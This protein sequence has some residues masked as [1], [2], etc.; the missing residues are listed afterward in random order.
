M[1]YGSMFRT[2][3]DDFEILKFHFRIA[4]VMIREENIIPRVCVC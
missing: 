1:H 2:N 4:K 3:M